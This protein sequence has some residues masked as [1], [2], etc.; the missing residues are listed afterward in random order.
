MPAPG[1]GRIQGNMYAGVFAG[2]GGPTPK[3]PQTW[4]T[5]TCPKE[6]CQAGPQVRCRRR[7]SEQFSS[8]AQNSPFGYKVQQGEG[9]WTSLKHP[10]PERTKLARESQK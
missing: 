5:V 9:R 7:I 4:R 1:H 2:T 8:A 3:H 6:T 10:H